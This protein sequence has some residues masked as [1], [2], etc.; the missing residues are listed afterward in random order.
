MGVVNV[1]LTPSVIGLFANGMTPKFLATV[2]ER[3][4]PNIVPITSLMAVDAETIIFGDFLMWKT[5][6]NLESYDKV[7]ILVVTEKLE[8]VFI[9]GTLQ[10]FE[11]SGDYVD[12]INSQDMFRYNAYTG[13]RRAGIIKVEATTEVGRLSK[14]YLV[15]GLLRLKSHRLRLRGSAEMHERV[16]EKFSR[17]N[18]LKVVA[19]M[20]EGGYPLA[21]PAMPMVA[22]NDS[23]LSFVLKPVLAQVAEETLVAACVL[24][25]EPICYQ[26]KGRLRGAGEVR[27]IELT[28]VYSACPP[29]VGKKIG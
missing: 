13:I 7:G 23:T 14:L 27:D 4:I 18:A 10:G 11:K 25:T 12:M 28:D 29:L 2:D 5:A 24:T 22:K 26:A 8:Y 6:R 21:I 9:K 20:G 16:S 1:S 15:T 19:W 3:G 17:T